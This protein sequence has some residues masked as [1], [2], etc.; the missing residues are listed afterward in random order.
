MYDFRVRAVNEI[1]PS[2]PTITLNVIVQD[3]EGN[4]IQLL[5]S[6]LLTYLKNIMSKIIF[7][8]LINIFVLSF[9]YFPNSAS[10][11]KTAIKNE[12]RRNS[13]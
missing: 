3:D 7:S 2:E 10:N 8:T 1:G 5:F 4:C 9:I 6:V 12:E 13:C 11:S